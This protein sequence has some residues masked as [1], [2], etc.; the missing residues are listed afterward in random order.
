[1]Q[2]EKSVFL[3]RVVHSQSTLQRQL[4]RQILENSLYSVSHLSKSY[5]LGVKI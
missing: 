1:M 5:L 2:F 4:R 3:R